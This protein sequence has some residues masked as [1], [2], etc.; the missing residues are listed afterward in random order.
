MPGGVKFDGEEIKEAKNCSYGEECKNYRYC[1]LK[2]PQKQ[3]PAPAKL[4]TAARNP[5]PGVTQSNP[6]KGSEK[7]NVDG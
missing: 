1:P 3:T 6:T 7:E 5:L 4:P 2:H